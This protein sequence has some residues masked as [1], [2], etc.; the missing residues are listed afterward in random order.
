MFDDGPLATCPCCDAA[1][2]HG[3]VF[4]CVPCWHA[5]DCVADERDAVCLGNR[6]RGRAWFYKRG[7]DRRAAAYE[8]TGRLTVCPCCGGEVGFGAE[9]ACASCWNACWNDGSAQE[10]DAAY[11]DVGRGRAWF[12]ERGQRL[13][14][15][16]HTL[17]K[18]CL[19]APC[20]PSAPFR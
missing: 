4:A 6:P 5:A 14:S 2:T 20:E 12:Y 13:R 17:C 1:L 8:R 10:R 19:R 7:R 9:C 11:I 18:A 16:V 15:N 3:E